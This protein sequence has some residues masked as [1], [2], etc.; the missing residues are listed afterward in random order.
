MKEVKLGYL[1]ITFAMGIAIWLCPIPEGVTTEAWHLF[2]IFVSTIIGIILKAAPMGTM[3]MLAVGL[4]AAFQL[5]APGDPG[6]SIMLSLRGFGD[7]VI[8]LIGISFIYALSG[9]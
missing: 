4:I 8:W 5:L 1:G 3:C 7:K 9:L 2:A 6:K